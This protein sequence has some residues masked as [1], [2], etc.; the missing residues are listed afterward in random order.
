LTELTA[1]PTGKASIPLP[2]FAKA[3]FDVSAEATAQLNYDM[4][5]NGALSVNP[6][7]RGS[8]GVGVSESVFTI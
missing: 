1:T 6:S 7:L 4:S 5:K 2:M 3:K 8:L